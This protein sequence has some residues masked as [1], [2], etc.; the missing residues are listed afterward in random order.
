MRF[1]Y[2]P[3]VEQLLL[4]DNTALIARDII[5]GKRRQSVQIEQRWADLGVCC[6]ALAAGERPASDM[7]RRELRKE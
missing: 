2:D 4:T 5:Y 3:R 6:D 1:L 7:P